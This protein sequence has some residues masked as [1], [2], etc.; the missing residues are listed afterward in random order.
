MSR[1]A[2]HAYVR[3]RSTILQ[4]P[5]EGTV[6]NAWKAFEACRRGKRHV[7]DAFMLQQRW[8]PQKVTEVA[9]GYEG[10][11]RARIPNREGAGIGRRAGR[12]AGTVSRD[13]SA[14][15][16]DAFQR[17]STR[18]VPVVQTAVGGGG[19]RSAIV[20]PRLIAHKRYVTAH[21]GGRT[22]ERCRFIFDFSGQA[23][24]YH[25]RY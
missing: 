6:D 5:R 2:V 4:Y 19:A 17:S 1:L 24:L 11:A 14:S 20:A 7:G 12:E 8:S 9:G 18:T 13:A 15:F 16:E 21:G 3:K 10:G 22:S 23:R 25:G